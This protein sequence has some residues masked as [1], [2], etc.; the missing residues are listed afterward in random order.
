VPDA[1]TTFLVQAEGYYPSSTNRR[2]WFRAGQRIPYDMAVEAGLAT[3]LAPVVPPVPPAVAGAIG[4]GNRAIV[5]GD[6]IALA[7]STAT[8]WNADGWFYQGCI[9]SGGRIR[10]IGN[11][12]V[13]GNT[14]AQ[15]LARIDA[16]VIALAPD[17]CVV[18]AG[19]NDV[20][21]A[22]ATATSIANIT[23]MVDRLQSAGIRPVLCT[24]P[25]R[26]DGFLTAIAALNAAVKET[27]ARRGL[28]LL[29]FHAA[30][31]DSTDGGYVSTYTS[32][33]VHPIR[34]GYKAMAALMNTVLTPLAPAVGVPLVADPVAQAPANLL[35]NGLMLDANTNGIADNWTH[36]GSGGTQT[37][38]IEAGVAPVLGN[39]QV[40]TTTVTAA[41]RSLQQ[42]LALSASLAVG[43]RLLFAGRFVATLEAGSQNL[44]IRVETPGGTSTSFAPVSTLTADVA[45]GVFAME[46][47]VP[48]G[49]TSVR[50]T[51]IPG[52]SGTGTVKVAQMTLV[53][54]T[55]LGVA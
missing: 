17:L 1:P 49:T 22:V 37:P 16:D 14:T 42:I 30:L 48:T 39:W 29:D 24:I 38:T 51:V 33:G 20:G 13:S 40:L 27:A 36:G 31:V 9:L 2:Y 11:A 35:T 55:K 54:L 19:T 15:M 8:A 46:F 10:P 5:L 6:S 34:A 28:T 23:A 18:L 45:A 4:I 50:P 21:T 44:T 12:G 3:A 52:S 43:D 7:N 53:N 41:A 47:V 25:P 32:D 26:D